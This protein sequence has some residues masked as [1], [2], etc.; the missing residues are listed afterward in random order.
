MTCARFQGSWICALSLVAG[1][2]VCS[3]PVQAGLFGLCQLI[4][5]FDNPDIGYY[6]GIGSIWGWRLCLC[7]GPAGLWNGTVPFA[8]DFS[9]WP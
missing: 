7:L 8:V 5:S 2:V 4:A 6:Y 3:C 9:V 1:L